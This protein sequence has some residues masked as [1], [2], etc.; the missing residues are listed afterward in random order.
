MSKLQLND[1]VQDYKEFY[2]RNTEQ[3]PKLIAEGRTPNR[4]DR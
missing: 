2:G 3:M 1:P 4:K